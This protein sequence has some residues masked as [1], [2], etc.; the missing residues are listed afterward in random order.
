[1]NSLVGDYSDEDT[2]CHDKEQS[3]GMLIA[4]PE[5]RPTTTATLTTMPT[6]TVDDVIDE[7]VVKRHDWEAK[8]APKKPV[9][10]K[11]D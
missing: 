11:I 4:K 3:M 1:M 10:Q 6:I 7:S 8:E 2:T 5:V 9:C